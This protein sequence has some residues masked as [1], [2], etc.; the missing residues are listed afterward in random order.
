MVA[1]DAAQSLVD[2]TVGIAFDGHG[3][4]SGNAHQ[5]AAAG[6]AKPAGRLFPFDAPRR[7]IQRFPGAET[8]SRK[9]DCGSS[10]GALYGRGFDELSSANI[11]LRLLIVCV[12]G[13]SVRMAEGH[14]K[15]L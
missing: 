6:A 9:Q 1:F 15:G 7:W 2:A 12:F 8:D 13:L 4:I 10:D 5:Q 3:P 14:A 11:H